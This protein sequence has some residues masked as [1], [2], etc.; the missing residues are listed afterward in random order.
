MDGR[1]IRPPDTTNRWKQFV[2]WGA[3][4]IGLLVIGFAAS[5]ELTLVVGQSA[6]LFSSEEIRGAVTAGQTFRAPY[7]GLNRIVVKMHTFDRVNTQDVT[8]R[9]KQDREAQEDIFT[10]SF[11]AQDV[12]NGKWQSFSFPPL[13]DSAGN[14]YY[15]YFESPGSTPGD[16]I[17]V[18]GQEGDPYPDGVG[19]VGGEPVPG[20]M[21]FRTY[22][23]AYLPD[24]LDFLLAWLTVDKPS[25]W[26]SRY[27]YLGLAL[28][29]IVLGFLLFRVVTRFVE[30][31]DRD[32]FE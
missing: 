32:T 6:S 25:L 9:L 11:N 20:D 1:S 5:S 15:F 13:G 30:T 8:F 7:P 3:V 22:Y 4:L 28:V 18:M 31:Q 21:A 23:Q 14:S 17:A 12:K 26:A 10:A 27:L 2:I 29:Y 24:R 16:A 19:Y